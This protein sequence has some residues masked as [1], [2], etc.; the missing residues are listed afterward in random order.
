MYEELAVAEA[1]NITKTGGMGD[2][3]L[4]PALTDIVQGG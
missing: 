1:S 4:W 2:L 3:S